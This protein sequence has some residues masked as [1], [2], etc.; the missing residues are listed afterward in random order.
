MS[1]IKTSLVLEGGGMRGAYS[2]GA[3]AWLIDQGI[4]FD[5][6]Y[7][8]STGAVH[9]VSFLMKSKEFLYELPVNK[10]TDPRIVGIRP[11]LRCGRIVDYDYLFDVIL[12]KE[13]NYDISPLKDCKDGQ[14]GLYSLSKGKT[15]YHSTK[16][17]SMKLLEASTSLPIL[18]TIVKEDGEEYLDGGITDMIPIQKAVDDGCKRHLIITTK[19]G[20][21]ERKPAKPFV[22]WLMKKSYPQCENISEDYKI[23]HINYMKQINMIK[24]L[25]KKKEAVYIYPSRHSNVTRL[26]GS[27]EELDALYKLGYSDMENRKE[28]ILSLFKKDE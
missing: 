19:P 16:D 25:E 18:G 20:D 26:G 2:A 1:K 12:A 3:L 21:Y 24:D 6:C 4:E 14:I 9:M 22:V 15:F 8:I 28:E 27:F 11:L 17:I 23:R 13:E 7:G 5:C 10:I